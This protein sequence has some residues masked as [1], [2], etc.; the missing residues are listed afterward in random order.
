YEGPMFLEYLFRKIHYDQKTI[1]LITPM[2]YLSI[3]PDNQVVQPSM[4]S[5]GDKG[6]HEVWLNGSND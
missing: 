1:K 2:E 4:S 3:Y 5:W 6:Y